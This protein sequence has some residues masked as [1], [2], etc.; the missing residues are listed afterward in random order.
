MRG[1]F[2]FIFLFFKI[3]FF[4]FSFFFIF[5]IFFVLVFM[6]FFQFSLPSSPGPQKHLFFILNLKFEARDGKKHLKTKHEAPI[7][8][9]SDLQ[10]DLGERLGGPAEK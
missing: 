3:C 2:F 7:P 8:K 9:R 1:S 6:F 4:I 5:S 10:K